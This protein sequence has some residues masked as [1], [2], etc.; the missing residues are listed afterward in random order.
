MRIKQINRKTICQQPIFIILGI[1]SLNNRNPEKGFY[2]K[3]FTACYNKSLVDSLDLI[4]RTDK[5]DDTHE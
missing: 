3:K 1:S 2:T 4:E 5:A